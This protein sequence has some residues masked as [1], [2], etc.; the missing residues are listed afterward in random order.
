MIERGVVDEPGDGVGVHLLRR[1]G[2]EHIRQLIRRSARVKPERVEL[3]RDDQRH[4]VMNR[5][6]QAVGCGGDNLS[7]IHI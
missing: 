4:A 3:F 1:V 5:R 7:L 2:Q 6:N